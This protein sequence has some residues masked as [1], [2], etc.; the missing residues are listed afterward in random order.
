MNFNISGEIIYSAGSGASCDFIANTKGLPTT[1][2][3]GTF[4]NNNTMLIEIENDTTSGA[5]ITTRFN[6]TNMSYI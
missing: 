3:L 4:D 6:Y 1:Q 5:D 2:M